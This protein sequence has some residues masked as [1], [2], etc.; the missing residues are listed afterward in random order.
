MQ[1]YIEQSLADL[2]DDQDFQRID[3][4]IGRFNLFE[5]VG[6]VRGEL[7]HS[8][9]LAYLLSPSR[10]HGLGSEPLLRFLRA[11]LSKMD[12]AQR[13]VRALELMV[14]DLDTAVVHRE[15]NGVVDL[16]VEARH[17]DLV[18]LIENKVDTKA[19][20]GQL[21]RY[22]EMVDARYADRRRLYVYLTPDGHAPDNG[23]YVAAGYDDVARVVE[24]IVADR[25]ESGETG[26]ILRHYVEML[27]RHIVPNQELQELAR[28]L[29]ERHKEA[30]DFVLKVRPDKGSLLQVAKGLVDD[31]D[32]LVQDKAT[33]S[34]L[35]FAPEAWS[36]VRN[37]NA[38]DPNLWTK[39]GRTAVFEVKTYNAE[40]YKY[41]VNL[42]LV[43][44]PA[45][46]PIRKALYDGACAMP[47]VFKGLVKPMGAQWVTIYARDL[48]S[49]AAGKLMKDEDER[50]AALQTAWAEFV[51]NDLPVLTER[52]AS[53]A[54]GR[55]AVAAMEEG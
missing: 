26:V 53:M 20:E 52:L 41:R 31:A 42:A 25:P 15:W 11:V 30:F 10:N 36:K 50:A 51:A 32:G 19:S 38:C 4:E 6:A 43:V 13:P 14:G 22:K 40:N 8:N 27:R 39:T 44:G 47:K 34:Q 5:A 16:L 45:P 21:D 48:V 33:S 12:P 17:L 3:R 24:G 18:V 29:Y 23:A 35:S 7:R 49:Q 28:A 1:L 2:V 55:P 9:F 37:L 54:E 46:A